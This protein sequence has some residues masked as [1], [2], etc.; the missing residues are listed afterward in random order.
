[1]ER[2]GVRSYC[3]SKW[4]RGGAAGRGARGECAAPAS[5]ADRAARGAPGMLKHGENV[6]KVMGQLGDG[7]VR[8]ALKAGRG[9]GL[10]RARGRA[11]LSLRRRRGAALKPR[12]GRSEEGDV[13]QR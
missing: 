8:A 7:G 6:A 10:G 4:W 9:Q 1:M 2:G 11:R 13:L 12:Q 3:A 5:V